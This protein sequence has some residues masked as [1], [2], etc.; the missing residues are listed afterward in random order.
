MSG[1]DCVHAADQHQGNHAH[2][3]LVAHRLAVDFDLRQFGDQV[4]ARMRAPLGNFF[5]RVREDLLDGLVDVLALFRPDHAVRPG[6]QPARG[7]W[8]AR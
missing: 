4:V 3:F 7:R 8:P 2:D 5:R 1:H 6:E